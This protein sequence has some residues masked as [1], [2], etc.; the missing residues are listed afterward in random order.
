MS[1]NKARDDEFINK[2]EPYESEF[3]LNQ[4]AVKDHAAVMK[5]IEKG[6]YQTHEELYQKLAGQG[7]HKK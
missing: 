5:A 6:N 3:I 7:I 1:E 4:Y 2:G